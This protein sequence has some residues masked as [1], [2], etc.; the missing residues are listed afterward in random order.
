MRLTP[1]VLTD[2]AALDGLWA[3]W[4]ALWRRVPG[5]SPFLASEW[6]KPWWAAFGTEAPVVATLRGDPGLLGVLP[7]YRLGEK[8]VPMGVGISDYFD[9]LLV[10]DAPAGGA[11]MLLGAALRAA[12]VARCDLPELPEAARLRAVA[13]PSGWLGE[14]WDGPPCP[15]LRLSPEPAVPKGMRRDLRQA[16]NR[17]ERGGEWTVQRA[18]TQHFPALLEGLVQLHGTRWKGRGEPGALAAPDVLAFHRAAWPGLLRAGLVRLSAMRLR[19]Q[20]AAMV[21]ALLGD[22]RIFF[23]LSGFDPALGFES[24][25]TILLGHMIEEAAHEGRR[26][27]HFLRGGEAYKYAWGAVDSFNIGRSFIRA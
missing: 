7:L 24:P 12:D 6:M 8:L 5:A 9:V 22:E 10:P 19:G 15:I 13:P 16:R 2:D 3:E 27:A 20:L 25:G 14:T 17:A 18:D 1:E 23:Y 21:Y 26:E 4:G 11:E